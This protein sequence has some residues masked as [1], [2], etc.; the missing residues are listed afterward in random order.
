MESF[1]LFPQPYE[2]V[3]T[4]FIYQKDNNSY[5]RLTAEKSNPRLITIAKKGEKVLVTG[6]KAE[7]LIGHREIS[8]EL[9]LDYLSLNPGTK[10]DFL[11]YVQENIVVPTFA[12]SLHEALIKVLLKQ[13]ISAKQAK[14]TLFHFY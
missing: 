7:Y 6:T 4:P 9:L 13:L 5:T 8:R 11:T 14:K 10:E 2:D 1:K 3:C 12:L